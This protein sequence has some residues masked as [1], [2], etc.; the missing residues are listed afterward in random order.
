VCSTL[1]AI[2]RVA[3]SPV[4]SSA[5]KRRIGSTANRANRSAPAG[6]STRSSRAAAP[7]GGNG[8]SSAGSSV[9]DNRCHSAA[10]RSQAGPS[11][12]PNV[13]TLAAVPARSRLSSTARPSG[14]GCAST[15]GACRQRSP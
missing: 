9:G 1:P 14:I 10:S 15:A 2:S 3:P 6:P 7:T 8:R 5:P 4:N 12:V 13:S 11:P